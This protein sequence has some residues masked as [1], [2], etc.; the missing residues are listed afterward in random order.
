MILR[1]SPVQMGDLEVSMNRFSSS[2]SCRL[3]ARASKMFPQC[4]QRLLALVPNL[5]DAIERLGGIPKR[6]QLSCYLAQIGM[7]L[8]ISRNPQ[9]LLVL[10]RQQR[11][12]FVP[13]F[14]E[15]PGGKRGKPAQAEENLDHF[16]FAY[17]G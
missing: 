13:I 14:L 7:K 4:F 2:F 16:Y 17:L 10:F 12:H 5:G 15:F 9:Y 6:R 1:S 3:A 8:N 11:V